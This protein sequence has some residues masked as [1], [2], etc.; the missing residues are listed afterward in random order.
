MSL[1][2]P[3]N[4]TGLKPHPP[5]WHRHTRRDVC[6]R[7]G[8]TATFCCKRVICTVTPIVMSVSE[9]VAQLLSVASMLYAPSHPSWCLW[10]SRWHSSTCCCKRVICT[11][12]PVVMSVRV[13]GT[14][15]LAVAS[16][17]YLRHQGRNTKHHVL[18]CR[19]TRLLHHVHHLGCVLFQPVNEVH[20]TVIAMCLPRPMIQSCILTVSSYVSIH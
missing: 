8:S 20:D 14:A 16:V 15:L 3:G 18:V 9:S 13:G 10:Q 11:V 12:T 4:S 1:L 6:V 2:P 19:S 17:L 5:R 7:V